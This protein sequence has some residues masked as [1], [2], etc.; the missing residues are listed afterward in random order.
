MAGGCGGGVAFEVL[1]EEIQVVCAM[2]NG[3]GGV[4][5]SVVRCILWQGMPPGLTC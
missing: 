5:V 2:L 1:G 3:Q 4:I